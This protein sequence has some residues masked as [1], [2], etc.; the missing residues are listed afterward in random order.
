MSAYAWV[1]P[2][3]PKRKPQQHTR[4]H[5]R[6][7]STGGGVAEV[8]A[9]APAAG[10]EA[11]A[12]TAAPRRPSLPLLRQSSLQQAPPAHHHALLQRQSSI[13]P[14][15]LQRQSSIQSQAS[16]RPQ[17][18]QMRRSS[19]IDAGFDSLDSL[20]ADV[21]SSSF[22]DGGAGTSPLP[23]SAP[24]QQLQQQQL[25][26]GAAAHH[27]PSSVADAVHTSPCLVPL[28][29]V[30]AVA[31]VGSHF[32]PL[33]V[34]PPAPGRSAAYLV[35]GA[36]G[37]PLLQVVALPSLALVHTHALPGVRVGGLAA[38]PRGGRL[39][40]VDSAKRRALHVLA[41]PLPGMPPLE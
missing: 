23:R 37:Q 5:S 27:R 10:D 3:H 11:G 9:A 16:Q 24:T 29:P 12:E 4:T 14:Q 22:D 36:L 35:V 33:C 6:R 13:Q 26:Q 7:L 32:R 40:V 31:G 19:S 17:Q 1:D 20:P 2:H 15:S 18:Q 39:L 30:A 38:D 28:G 25:A 41:W 34:V 8:P 21:A